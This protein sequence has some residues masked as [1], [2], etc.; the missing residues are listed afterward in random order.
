MVTRDETWVH[1]FE[2]QRKIDTKIWATSRPVIAKIVLQQTHH[3]V[4]HTGPH[5]VAS[6]NIYQIK[7]QSFGS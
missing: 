5:R 2:L 1:F 4:T 3:I 7:A 6:S